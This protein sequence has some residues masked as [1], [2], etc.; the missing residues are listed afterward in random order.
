VAEDVL[1]V[2]VGVLEGDGGDEVDE[3]AEIR[4]VELELGVGLVE[5][6]FQLWVLALDGLQRVVDEPAGG[7]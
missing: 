3:A 1:R 5:D 7:G 4:R 2:Q 6:A